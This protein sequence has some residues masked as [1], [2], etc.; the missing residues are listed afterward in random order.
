MAA[1]FLHGAGGFVEDRPML[2][3]LRAG[4][5]GD[6]LAPNLDEGITTTQEAWSR[7]IVEHL[8]AGVDVVVGHSFGGS[9]VL[10]LL[11]E[12]DPGVRRLILLAAPD[13]GPDGWDVPEFALPE[14]A[15][16]RLSEALE[17]ELHHCLDDEVVPVEHV[18]QLAARLP[19]ARVVRH[20]QGGHQFVGPVI[21]AVVRSLQDRAG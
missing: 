2:E 1:L 20:Q 15:D 13:W 19:R 8:G 3:A 4:F 21:E 9:C 17:V 12:R 16:E 18:Q 5:D 10:R 6:V 14:D 7:R 11:T